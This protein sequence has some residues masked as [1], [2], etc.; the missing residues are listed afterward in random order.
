MA[1][2]RTI[3]SFCVL[4]GLTACL[5]TAKA[6]DGDPKFEIE[7][8]DIPRYATEAE[9]KSACGADGVVWADRKTGFFYPK[10]FSDYGTTKYGTYT[11]HKLAVKADY[12]SF[13]PVEESGKGRTFPQ[14]FCGPC[15]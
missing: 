5:G 4:A 6:A 3:L 12:W 1:Q 7:L 9:A 10:F 8:G 11:C 13:A 15:Y 2:S 14:A